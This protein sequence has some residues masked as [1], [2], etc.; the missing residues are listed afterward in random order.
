MWDVDTIDWKKMTQDG[1]N[2][3]SIVEKV[4]N[5]VSAGSIVLMHLGGENTFKA[6]SRLIPSLRKKGYSFAKISTLIAIAGCEET[7]LEPNYPKVAIAGRYIQ[8][9]SFTKQ[10]NLELEIKNLK[11]LTTPKYSLYTDQTDTKTRLYLGNFANSLDA[12]NFLDKSVKPLVSDAFIKK[13][14]IKDVLTFKEVQ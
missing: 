12:E 6:I 4:E 10:T 8:V 11:H 13:L 14:E 2:E 3:S 9:G 7:K 1:P 5:S